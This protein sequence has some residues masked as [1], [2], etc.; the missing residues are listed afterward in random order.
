MKGVG[1]VSTGAVPLPEMTAESSEVEEVT[2]GWGEFVSKHRSPWAQPGVW[3][4]Q[5]FCVGVDVCRM[6]L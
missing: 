1:Q 4:G 3:V 2:N 6:H 5:G